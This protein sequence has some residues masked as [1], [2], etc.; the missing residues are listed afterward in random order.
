MEVVKSI[1]DLIAVRFASDR[2]FCTLFGKVFVFW[3]NSDRLFGGIN[4]NMFVFLFRTV[5]VP[6]V[7]QFV[8]GFFYGSGFLANSA[9]DID[10]VIGMVRGHCF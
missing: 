5:R 2:G 4:V 10:F 3:F 8:A 6:W 9:V 1:I 7:Q